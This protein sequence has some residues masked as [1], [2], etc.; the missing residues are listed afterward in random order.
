PDGIL[1]VT[2]TTS[3]DTAP[4]DAFV[5]D[6]STI[7]DKLLDTPSIAIPLAPA[8]VSFRNNYNLESTFDGGVLEISING[9]AFADITSGGGSFVTGGYNDTIST[10]FQSPIA[11]RSAW[12]GSSGGY[13]STKANLP[14]AALGQN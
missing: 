2:S 1:W 12:S 10:A 13:V 7:S 11:G 3:P 4:N 5:N 9:G 14:G 8:Q 6:P